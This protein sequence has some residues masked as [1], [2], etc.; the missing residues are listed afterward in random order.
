MT[1]TAETVAALP[2]VEAFTSEIRIIDGC[3]VRVPL[4]ADVKLVF[5]TDRDVDR[6][7]DADGARWKLCQ[8]LTGEYARI[9]TGRV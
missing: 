2:I 4:A 8:R 1:W 6:Y 3:R 7:V 5:V 9:C